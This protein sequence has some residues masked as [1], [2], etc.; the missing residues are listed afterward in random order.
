M[1][2][3]KF[4]FFTVGAS[5]V[6]KASIYCALGCY[7]VFVGS[8]LLTMKPKKYILFHQGVTEQ[9]FTSW[10][11]KQGGVCGNLEGNFRRLCDVSR[12]EGMRCGLLAAVVPQ[13][14][15]CG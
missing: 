6:M 14:S 8:G 9:P 5:W 12:A 1:K 10:S 7:E 15:M 3:L 4:V 13:Q 2:D 11:S